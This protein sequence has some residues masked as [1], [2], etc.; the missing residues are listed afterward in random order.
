VKLRRHRKPPRVTVTSR[1]V[2]ENP[3]RNG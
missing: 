3:P 2:V 1:V